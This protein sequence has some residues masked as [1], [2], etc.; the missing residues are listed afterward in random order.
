LPVCS[1]VWQRIHCRFARSFAGEFIAGLT[2]GLAENSLRVNFFA[3]GQNVAPRK[4]ENLTKD[5]RSYFEEIAITAQSLSTMYDCLT[6]LSVETY[7][8]SLKMRQKS[9][10]TASDKV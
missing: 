7:S 10:F 1:Q 2:A 8:D 3:R 5:T 9:D 4:G 6:H